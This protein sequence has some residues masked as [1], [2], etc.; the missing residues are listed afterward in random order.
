M[1]QARQERA[2]ANIEYAKIV[3]PF[4]GV[5]THR[6]FHVGALIRS[7]AEGGQQPLLTVKRIDM[8]RVVVLVPD[9]DVALTTVGDRAEVT[10]DALGGRSFTGILARIARSEDAERMMRVEIDLKNPGNFLFDGM[11][12]K[13]VINLGHDQL[14][15]T[16]PSAC[17]V[18]HSGRAGGVVYLVRDGVAH[19]TEVT[20]GGD[21]GTLAEIRSG[22]STSDLVVIPSGTPLEDG[23]RVTAVERRAS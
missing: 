22:V 15:F 19:R 1:A 5:I 20:L 8:M 18:E 6:T 3:A 2:K 13:A 14:S 17:V 4:D 21:N 11:Y 23:M 10:V 7:A 9:T 16:V 12:G